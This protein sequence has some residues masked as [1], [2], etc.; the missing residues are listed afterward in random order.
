MAGTVAGRV[1]CLAC[2]ARH[3]PA[4]PHQCSALCYPPYHAEVMY[5]SPGWSID[6]LHGRVIS[7]WPIVSIL[8]APE[9][10]TPP[11]IDRDMVPYLVTWSEAP[12]PR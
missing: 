11:G 10:P 7:G 5:G 8:S 12:A 3:G 1:R 2:M 4:S 9:A 6:Q